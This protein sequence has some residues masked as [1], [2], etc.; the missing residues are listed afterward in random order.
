LVVRTAE[1]SPFFDT[2]AQAQAATR[3]TAFMSLPC[4]GAAM[5][6]VIGAQ[7]NDMGGISNGITGYP[8]NMQPALAYTVDS[9]V[10]SGKTAWTLFMSRSVK[11]DYSFGATLNVFRLIRS[12]AH[13]ADFFWRFHR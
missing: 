9:G 4:G 1:S 13:A 11:P 6:A 10:A 12:A 7:V 5:A 8:S 3:G 2:Y